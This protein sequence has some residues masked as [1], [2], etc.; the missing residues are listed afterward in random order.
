MGI[1]KRI[2][3]DT[4]IRQVLTLAGGNI[5]GQLVLFLSLPLLQRYFYSPGSFG[6]FT[7]YVSLSELLINISGLK[8]EYGIVPLRR[9]KKALNLLFTSI[10]TVF[11]TS[12]LTLL[13]YAAV[14]FGSSAGSELRVLGLSGFLLPVSVFCWG[15][16]NALGY[17]FN[18][19]KHYGRISGSKWVS[20]L[21][22]EP[23]KFAVQPRLSSGAGLI[24]GRVAGQFAA[25][26][27]MCILFW[28]H[29][30]H[31]LR[32]YSPREMRRMLKEER[33]YPFYIMPGALIT[34]LITA[35][36]VNFFSHYFG[37]EKTGVL[38]VS[39]SYL[40][41][42]FG[43][44]SGAFGQVF[45]RRISEEDNYTRLS[46]L[47]RRFLLVLSAMA[48]AVILF[49]YLFP[50]SWVTALLG[51]RWTQTLPVMRIMVLWMSIAFV[52]S[53]L[54][55]I[56]IRL[57]NQ[58]GLLILEVIHLVLVLAALYG[59]YVWR[60]DFFFT[61]CAFSLVQII[62]YLAV[63]LSAFLFLNKKNKELTNREK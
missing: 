33:R 34:A 38:G 54:S 8:Y 2:Q 52:S 19:E 27:Y 48:A 47:F 32:L 14:Y 46:A 39:V 55:F 9:H 59:S 26:I 43:I 10:V 41:V 35:I 58:R 7:V 30:R 15:T 17:W 23:V 25:C 50:N 12:I 21:V 3:N 16:V 45:F 29:Q 37:P 57:H 22:S 28:K 63:I 51:E 61:L 56:H 24:S 18:R 6:L 20:S 40:G 13:G 31:Y 53:A 5:G 4:F 36:Y 44:V 1:V 60:G 49:I 42:A 11:T 62:H